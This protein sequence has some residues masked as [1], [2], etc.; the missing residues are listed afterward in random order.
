MNNSRSF[1]V[2]PLRRRAPKST[3]LGRILDALPQPGL[4]VDAR[5]QRVWQGNH[6]LRE[7]CGYSANE[8]EGLDLSNLFRPFDPAW[9]V[10]SAQLET[11]HVPHS[12]LLIMPGHCETLVNL[13]CQPLEEAGDW[14]LL[15]LEMPNTSED[16]AVS[17]PFRR[18][19]DNYQQLCDALQQEQLSTALQ[20][21]LAAGHEL[22]GAAVL[23]VYQ[24]SSSQLDLSLSAI[25]GGLLPEILPS[26][27]LVF[28]KT[29]RL[30]TPG[31]RPRSTLLRYA[32]IHE[33]SYLASAPLGFPDASIGLAVMAGSEDGPGADTLPILQ[34]L[35]STLNTIIQ[36]YAL[37]TNLKQ[38]LQAEREHAQTNEVI[39][40]GIQDSL[41]I[42][43]QE[44]RVISLNPQAE[45]TLG[46]TAKEA[47]GH[48]VDSILIGTE[49]LL[50][51][52][53]QAQQGRPVLRQTNIHLYRRDGIPFLA[54]VRILPV[55]EQGTVQG[56]A[57]LIQDLSE[58]E[59]TETRA[60]QL[61]QRALLGEVTEVF[62]H[63]VRNPINNISTGLQL[64]AHT[65]SASDPHYDLISRLQQDCDRLT[66]LMDSVLS[67]SRPTEYNLVAIDLEPLLGRLLER[68]RP[69]Y[70]RVNVQT[71]L[72]V[73]PDTPTAWGDPRAL[74][75]VFTNLI[76]NAVQA[77]ESQGGNLSIR[78][79]PVQSD[80][81]TE[82]VEV[83]VADDGPGIAKEH[84]DKIFQPF[85]TTRSNG[86]GLGLAITRR[87]II[88]HKG[89]IQV[90]SLPGATVFTIHLPVAPS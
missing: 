14:W 43:D 42:L 61:E 17:E 20:M 46:Y 26:T 15:T 84:L 68:L 59:Q 45:E 87:I 37:T 38:Q 73:A 22:S 29:P 39:Q 41:I 35:A 60:R 88:A 81:E 31:I 90:N 53:N 21:V 11:Q 47:A 57:I 79:Q 8:L 52:F 89:T 10:S 2:L 28:H 51:E 65:M 44:R 85:F 50:A 18:W 48:S 23:G 24:A 86:T 19:L 1:P 36:N 9:F 49:T 56:L 67:F 76:T 5:M 16:E 77:M 25:E 78:I 74:E 6:K 64:M 80:G 34:L 66:G 69:R 3:H 30:W 12:T 27:D 62:A 7:L 40:R 33:Y 4:V 13:L 55:K 83:S 32:R 70:A 63:E 58:Q 72:Q 75:Q 82:Y 54:R 71:R